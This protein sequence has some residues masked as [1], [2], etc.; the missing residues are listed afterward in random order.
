MQAYPAATIRRDAIL[1]G[2]TAD[3]PVGRWLD[4]FMPY[5]R[6]RLARAMGVERVDEVGGVLCGASARIFVSAARVDV[7]MSM[8]E[9]PV[10]IRLAGLDRDPG[11][12][13]AAGRSI[14]YHFD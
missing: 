1:I 9:H 3:S 6:A 8:E 4:W 5:A 7:M 12:V 2:E 11:W 10:A 13:P 14:H